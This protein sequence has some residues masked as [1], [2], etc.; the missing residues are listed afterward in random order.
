[1]FGDPV[2]LVAEAVC[3]PRQMNCVIQ[4]VGWRRARRYRRLVE[5]G[6]LHGAFPFPRA[7]AGDRGPLSS[8]SD[9]LKVRFM[10]YLMLR[11]DGSAR[12]PRTGI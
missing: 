11:E 12:L 10:L 4:S 1:M 8:V 9:G 3:C 7:A 6:K 5:D 2:A